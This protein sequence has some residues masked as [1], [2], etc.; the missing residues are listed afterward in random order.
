[1]TISLNDPID[2]RVLDLPAIYSNRFQVIRY[3]ANGLIRITIG[4]SFTP[5]DPRWRV[6]LII[7]H[8]MALELIE[9]LKM[10]TAG[11]THTGALN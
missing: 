11:T 8:E 7:D 1:M 6:S 5:D 10:V 4:E 9:L 3:G 2:P